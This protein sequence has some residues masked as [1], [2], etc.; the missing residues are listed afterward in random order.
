MSSNNS[1][2]PRASQTW[3]TLRVRGEHEH[4]T[5]HKQSDMLN[6][7]ITNDKRNRGLYK[8]LNKT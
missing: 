4:G 3:L 6:N 7:T 1:P 2:T 5:S 8:A